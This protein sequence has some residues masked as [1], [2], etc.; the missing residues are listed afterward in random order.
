MRF[1]V[2]LGVVWGLSDCVAAPPLQLGNDTTRITLDATHGYRLVSLQHLPS[3]TEFLPDAAT[4]DSLWRVVVR[5]PG[6]TNHVV[7]CGEQAD[8]Q[9]AHDWR[10]GK[11]YRITWRGVVVA[12]EP[13][14]LDVTVTIKAPAHTAMTYWNIAVTNRSRPSTPC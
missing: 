7:E 6:R 12:D 3:G 13:G 8:L 10:G 4:G 11:V 9:T 14:A 5:D 1:L 2:A